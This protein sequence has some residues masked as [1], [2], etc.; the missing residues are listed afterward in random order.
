MKIRMRLVHLTMGFQGKPA[1]KRPA[2]AMEQSGR[3]V[4]LHQLLHF[5]QADSGLFAV[6]NHLV[7]VDG[8]IESPWKRTF[9]PEWLPSRLRH[10]GRLS[11][12]R[13]LDRI[14]SL[15]ES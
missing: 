9:G 4:V 12:S 7:K 11:S 1:A 8:E 6:A 2:D 14:A 3:H 13:L 10:T 15:A 5:L